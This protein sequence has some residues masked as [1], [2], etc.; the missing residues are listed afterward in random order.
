MRSE[1]KQ[2]TEALLRVQDHLAV[3]PPAESPAYV[4]QKQAL[5]DVIAKLTEHSTD[6]GAAQ[7]MSRAATRRQ[8]AQRRVLREKHLSPIAQIARAMLRDVPGIEVAVRVPE[9]H[10]KTFKLVKA[11][12]GFR[13]AAA[14]YE[15]TFIEGGRP[16]DF[17]AQL[18]DAIAK[19]QKTAS[20]KSTNLGTHVAA[21]VGIGE[22]LKRGR[23]AVEL[24]DTMVRATYGDRPDLLAAWDVAK[25]VTGA[26]GGIPVTTVAPTEPTPAAA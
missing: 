18:D 21:R 11:A 5:D 8:A 22:Q 20:G 17:L 23:K 26:P 16:Q 3:H 9:W 15:Q 13:K 7:R 14:Q 12:Q 6:Q 19:L 1:E 4:A 10:L 24:I 2:K 25:R